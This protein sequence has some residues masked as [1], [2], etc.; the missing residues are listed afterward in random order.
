M[1]I[2]IFCT[3]AL[4][5]FAPHQSFYVSL[6][7]ARH[8]RI[9]NLGFAP[10]LPCRFDHCLE[11]LIVAW[12]AGVQAVIG[13]DRLPAVFRLHALELFLILEYPNDLQQ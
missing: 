11:T 9:I 2:A 7:F 8:R 1:V 6:K 4:H 13:G 5:A 3:F 10:E 12:M